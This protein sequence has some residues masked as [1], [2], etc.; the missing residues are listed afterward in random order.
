[1]NMPGFTAEASL[2]DESDRYQQDATDVTQ[3]A[4]VVPAWWHCIVVVDSADGS[5]W[6]SC[7]W[8]PGNI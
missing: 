7:H 3:N 2:N 5:G 6:I 4:G 1:M 8:I